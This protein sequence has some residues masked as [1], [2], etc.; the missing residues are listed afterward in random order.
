MNRR[1][2]TLRREALTELTD[3]DLLAAVGAE[4]QWSTNAL[5]CPANTCQTVR[6]LFRTLCICPTE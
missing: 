1:T 2:L 5:T 4:P 3:A 6:S